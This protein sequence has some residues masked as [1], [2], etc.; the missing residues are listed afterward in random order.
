MSELVDTLFDEFA[1][2]F[3]RGERPEVGAYVGR[4]GTDAGDLAALIDV[5]L[6]V[7]VPPPPSETARQRVRAL[8]PQPTLRDLRSKAGLTVDRMIDEIVTTFAI[9][10]AKRKRV[11][12]YYRALE[13][14]L[15][16]PS[17]V[18]SS[19]WDLLGRMLGAD[20]S[21]LVDA[22]RH[23]PAAEHALLSAEVV[24]DSAPSSPADEPDDVDRLFTAGP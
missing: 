3:A 2:A 19:L 11:K 22:A 21:P 18:S 13:A 12:D 23:E 24:M 17:A 1:A 10:P 8:G 20:P 15:L 6:V 16:D 4:A 14:D 7:A 5:F 9:A